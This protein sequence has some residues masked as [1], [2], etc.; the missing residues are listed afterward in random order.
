MN[1]T[2]DYNFRMLKSIILVFG[3]RVRKKGDMKRS[4]L[5][6]LPTLEVNEAT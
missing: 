2:F 1:R 6:Y 3:I 5:I 4:M